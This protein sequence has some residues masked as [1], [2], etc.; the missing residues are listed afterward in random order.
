MK[1][2]EYQSKDILRKFNVAVPRGQVA[3]T[4]DENYQNIGISSFLC[5]YLAG[6]AKDWGVKGFTAYVMKE[7][8]AMLKVFKKLFPNL[9]MTIDEP[10]VYLVTMDFD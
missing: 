7:N 4:V 10:G 9:K 6:A 2:H 1:I 3:F 8:V 5:E